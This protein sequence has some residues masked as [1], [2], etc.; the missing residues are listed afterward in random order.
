MTTMLSQ[1]L[2]EP[3]VKIIIHAG[4][5]DLDLPYKSSG[6]G[7]AWRLNW[8][9]QLYSKTQFDDYFCINMRFPSSNETRHLTQSLMIVVRTGRGHLSWVACA[10]TQ[11]SGVEPKVKDG[12]R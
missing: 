1:A 12:V 10:H 3:Y 8:C 5:N 4:G 9:S 7:G 11:F 6:E 2:H